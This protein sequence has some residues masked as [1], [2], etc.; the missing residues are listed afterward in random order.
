LARKVTKLCATDSVVYPHNE[1]NG[2]R[3]ADERPAYSTLGYD[4]LYCLFT[5]LLQSLDVCPSLR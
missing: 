1:L 3:K 5:P 4:I 2:L